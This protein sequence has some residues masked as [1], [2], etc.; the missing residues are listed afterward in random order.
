MLN[1]IYQTVSQNFELNILNVSFAILFENIGNNNYNTKRG[2]R[3]FL[4]V[5][6]FRIKWSSS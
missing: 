4:C 2:Q 6:C 3:S 5:M 1:K